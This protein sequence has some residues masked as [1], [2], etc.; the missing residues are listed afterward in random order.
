MTAGPG[1]YR[2]GACCFLGL[3]HGR[4]QLLRPPAGPVRAVRIKEYKRKTA[5]TLIVRA[6]FC[7]AEEGGFENE[8]I[9]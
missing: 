3:G 8:K 1:A 9:A 6:V 2:S 5:R 7:K 4:G